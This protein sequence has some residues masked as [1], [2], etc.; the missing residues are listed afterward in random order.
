MSDFHEQAWEDGFS[1]EEEYLEHL[2]DKA[3]ELNDPYDEEE[4][5][6]NKKV[7]LFI[8]DKPELSKYYAIQVAK[9]KGFKIDNDFQEWMVADIDHPNIKQNIAGI[10][11]VL[12]DILKIKFTPKTSIKKY[13]E[14]MNPDQKGL[15]F[16]DDIYFVK[17]IPNGNF[18]VWVGS[19]LKG[20]KEKS[21][22]IKLIKQKEDPRALVTTINK[23]GKY[24]YS[25]ILRPPIDMSDDD[26][27]DGSMA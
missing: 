6:F 17:D 21:K 8:S 4:E 15:K 19:P 27:L 24:T 18:Y 7:K 16:E 25:V 2:M 26:I 20:S 13:H 12:G 9:N 1:D 14:L 23:S 3:A 5:E 22:I 11:L 10:K